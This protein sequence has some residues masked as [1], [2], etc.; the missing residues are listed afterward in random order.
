M[1][2]IQLGQEGKFK[3]AKAAL[4]CKLQSGADV[5][6]KDEDGCTWLMWAVKWNH[7]AMVALLLNS[8]NI[9]VNLKDNQGWCALH[10]ALDWQNNQKQERYNHNAVAALLLSSPNIDVNQKDNEDRCALRFAALWRRN[11]ALKL[12]L[13]FPNIDVNI[14]DK[15]GESAL[16]CAVYSN[17]IEGLKLLLAVPTIDV[18]I[19]T[20]NGQSALHRAVYS[21][22]VFSMLLNVPNIDVN[23][24]DNYGLS[25]VSR[26]VGVD[27]GML[28]LLLS[29]PSLTARTLNTKEIYNKKSA[30]EDFGD[31]PVMQAVKRGKWKHLEVLVAD[32]RVDLDTTDKEGRSLDEV[33]RGDI[34]YK[35]RQKLV[36]EIKLKREE[37]RRL[38]REQQRQVSKVLLDGLYDPDSPISKL[39]GVRMEVMGEIIWQKLVENWQIFSEQDEQDEDVQ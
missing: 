11:E 34:Y 4:H 39:L 37:R 19:V 35:T 17:N 24:V 12:M 27:T 36:D 38:I 9:D 7:R 31:T 26:A 23:I 16:W 13:N 14:V 8:P 25:A 28:K 30:L 20:N 15:Y 5:N 33:A 22:C 10:W 2:L 1:S 3:Q 32:P 29:H 6:T 18:N 21:Q